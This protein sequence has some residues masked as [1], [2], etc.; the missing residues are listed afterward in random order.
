MYADRVE[1][2]VP[3]ALVRTEARSSTKLIPF[4]VRYAHAPLLGRPVAS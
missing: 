1:E 2:V 4:R 3:F